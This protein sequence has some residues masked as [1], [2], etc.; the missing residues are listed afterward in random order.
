MKVTFLGTGA[1]TS[2]PLPFC[3]CSNCRQAWT[4]GG[5]SLRRRSSVLINNDLIIDFGPDV[6]TAAFSHNVSLW[7]VRYCL[8]THPHSDH[9]D[10]NHLFTRHP[11]YA[12][13][14][15]FLLHLYASKGALPRLVMA[16]KIESYDS[17]LISPE[18]CRSV[19]NLQFHQVE[20][21]CPFDVGSYLVTAFPANHDPTVEPL[22]YTIKDRTRTVFYGADTATLPEQVWRGFHNHKLRF[23]IVILDHTYGPGSSRVNQPDH[24]DAFQFVRHVRRLQ[25]EKLLND[26]A[27]IFA[28]HLSHEGNPIHDE[29]VRYALSNGY[30]VAYD[31]LVVNLK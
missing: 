17:D 5:P 21:F 7:D 23:D 30:Q 20:V 11:E 22:L 9:F 29:L 16:S 28:T 1:A 10:M 31:G 6:M 3:H 14:D 13:K 19:L 25:D 4:I 8:L 15:I 24:L 12:V 27:C 26:G 18:Y 2:Y